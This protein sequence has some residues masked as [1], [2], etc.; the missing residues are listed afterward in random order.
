MNPDR[1]EAT[2]QARGAGGISG[3]TQKR[4]QTGLIVAHIE[5]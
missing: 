1:E 3:N 4:N 2:P 5:E